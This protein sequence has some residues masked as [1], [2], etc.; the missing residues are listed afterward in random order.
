M[1]LAKKA[2]GTDEELLRTIDQASN[3]LAESYG[4]I[5]RNFNS[6]FEAEVNA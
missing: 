3:K 6:Y 4:I 1:M 5:V 2:Y